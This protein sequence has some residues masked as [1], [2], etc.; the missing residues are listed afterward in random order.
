MLCGIELI[1][2]T[3]G[4]FVR[5]FVRLF[6]C[7]SVLLCRTGSLDSVP[8]QCSNQTGG[9]GGSRACAWPEADID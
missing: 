6:I 3:I 2:S 9:A 4:K 7:L 8:V 1:F 5:V